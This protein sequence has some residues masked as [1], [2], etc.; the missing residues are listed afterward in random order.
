MQHLLSLVR[1]RQAELLAVQA[2]ERR[3]DIR[4]LCVWAAPGETD[5]AV[6]ARWAHMLAPGQP[7]HIGR[8]NYDDVTAPP[9]PTAPAAPPSEE[10][11]AE[12]IARVAAWLAAMKKRKD[13]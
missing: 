2:A 8:W 12:R 1:E 4:P 5:D 3:A 7:L 13:V 9:S 6:E 10:S 11:E